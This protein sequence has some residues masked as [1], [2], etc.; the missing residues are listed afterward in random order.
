MIQRN[1]KLSYALGWADLILF[2]WPY[3]P[4]Q[5]TGLMRSFSNY[6]TFF[7]KSE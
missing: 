3:Y 2:K 1:G 6:M 5:S 7:I 4:K